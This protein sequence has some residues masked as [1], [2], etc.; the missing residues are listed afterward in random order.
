MNRRHSPPAKS[1]EQNRGVVVVAV[2]AQRAA[3]PG[4]V[5][6]VAAGAG[7]V[8]AVRAAARLVVAAGTAWEDGLA[9]H[10]PR[11]HGAEG[12]GGEGGE[13]ARVSGH[14]VG[15]AFTADQPG[16]DELARVAF[17]DGRAGGQ[18]R[19]R[20]LPHAVSSTPSGSL[21]VVYR[22]VV[23]RWPGRWRGGL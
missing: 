9:A 16:A 10:A 6:T 20:R 3:Q 1:V 22:G 12:G 14:G 17:V 21:A 4:I 23:R 13:H 15:D 8:A 2:W 19:S 7:D 11:V 5:L 18:M